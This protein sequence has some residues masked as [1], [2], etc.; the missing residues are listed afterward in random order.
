MRV[1]DALNDLKNAGVVIGLKSYALR[2]IISEAGKSLDFAKDVVERLVASR[3][4]IIS[5]HLGSCKAQARRHI[6]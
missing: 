6:L 1:K 2:K 4:D 3:D 5:V